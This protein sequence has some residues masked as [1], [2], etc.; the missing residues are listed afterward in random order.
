MKNKKPL[1]SICIPTYNRSRYLAVSLN[2]IIKHANTFYG[3]IE[4]IISDNASTD[5]TA[6]VVSD[7][8]NS[9]GALFY[10]R[11]D[12][13]LW[14]DRNLDAV[15]KKATGTYCWFLSDD[16]LVLDWTI[17]YI[18]NLLKT[19][20]KSNYFCIEVAWNNPKNLW[21]E[22]I[23]EVENGNILLQRYG[24][25]GWLI[26]QNIIRREL[27]P[28]NLSEY[29][30]NYWI[31]LSIIFSI[32]K[33]KPLVLVN[34]SLIKG[35]RDQCTW[36]EWWKAF[37]TFSSL[38]NIILSWKEIGYDKV[39]IES[40]VNDF[41]VSLPKTIFSAKLHGLPKT[42]ENLNI[43]STSFSSYRFYYSV[44][45]IIYEIPG[46]VFLYLRRILWK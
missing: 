32:I 20:P 26:S 40:V 18:L 33:D 12:S 15:I 5:D 17:Q 9:F 1:L 35:Q 8:Q 38:K 44:S 41:V 46:W 19:Y 31:H 21:Y 34:K 45:R 4:I 36:A 23:I 27:C 37:L 10:Y 29:Y 22:E 7:A 14:Y 42:I 24:L 25:V 39:I 13:N 6:T 28:I 11:N 3:E 16:E 30:G 43:L 2:N